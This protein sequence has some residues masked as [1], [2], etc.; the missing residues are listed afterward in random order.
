LWIK[1]FSYLHDFCYFISFSKHKNELSVLD[2]ERLSD[3]D[4][5][6]VTPPNVAASINPNATSFE[7]EARLKWLAEEGR[8]RVEKVRASLS[9]A[10]SDV[11]SS[12]GRRLP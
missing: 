8:E 6:D 10:S 1:H 12:R 7:E 11:C 2:D 3:D 5:D 4:D 9:K